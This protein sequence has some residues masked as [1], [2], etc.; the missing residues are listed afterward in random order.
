[1]GMRPR[2]RERFRVQHDGACTSDAD[3]VGTYPRRIESK[4]S[5]FDFVAR[6]SPTGGKDYA[7]INA[8]FKVF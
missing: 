8:M 2:T 1:M 4:K 7:Y 5:A 6:T 3:G